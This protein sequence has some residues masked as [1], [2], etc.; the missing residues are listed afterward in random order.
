MLFLDDHDGFSLK[1]FANHHV[2]FV[3]R[4]VLV[5]FHESIELPV[6]LNL[7]HFQL[8]LNRRVLL[9]ELGEKILDFL[10]FVHFFLLFFSLSAQFFEEQVPLFFL[11]NLAMSL[12]SFSLNVANE[13][14][15]LFLALGLKNL[16]SE[17]LNWL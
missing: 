11:E 10:N 5:S 14:F 9:E 7:V 16:A 1:D 12:L 4:F 13:F 3:L 2:F 8:R 17:L 6:I 15:H